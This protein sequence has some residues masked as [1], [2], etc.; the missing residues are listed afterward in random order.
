MSSTAKI[1]AALIVSFLLG[2][3]VGRYSLPAKIVTTEKTVYQDRVVIKEVEA[4]HVD[5]KDNKITI[6]IE[7][8]KPDGTRTI[9]T[10]IIDKDETIVVD[11]SSKDSSHD[12][13]VVTQIDKTVTYN[14]Q[15]WI[16]SAGLD[17]NAASFPSYGFGGSIQKRILGPIYIG[18]F[19]YSDK[20]F[21]TNI[22]I[23]F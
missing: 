13:S 11:H 20:S 16:I 18:A 9:E 8:I 14:T 7:T 22:G 1:I 21:G 15:S 17:S 6:R 4:K 5:K 12:T 10:K 3:A 19:G 2:A 23:A